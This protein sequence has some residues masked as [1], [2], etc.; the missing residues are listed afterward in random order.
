MKKG[1][2]ALLC[3]S[4][5]VALPACNKDEGSEKSDRKGYGK[6]EMRNKE[7]RKEKRSKGMKEDKN[8][9]DREMMPRRAGSY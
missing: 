6:K 7:D 8:A 3:L 5:I 9:Q 4:L 2:L 1:L